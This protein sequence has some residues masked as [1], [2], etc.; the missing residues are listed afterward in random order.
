MA[1]YALKEMRQRDKERKS[2]R[3][4]KCTNMT[5]PAA[6]QHQRL[7]TSYAAPAFGN[8]PIYGH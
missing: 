6:Q 1:M 2:A 4:G 8:D 3:N 5:D 7:I